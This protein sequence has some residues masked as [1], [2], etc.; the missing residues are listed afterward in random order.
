MLSTT[1]R[2][3]RSVYCAF[4]LAGACTCASGQVVYTDAPDTPLTTIGTFIDLDL[5]GSTDLQLFADVACTADFQFCYNSVNVLSLEPAAINIIIDLGP[6][7]LHADGA[8]AFTDGAEII[9]DFTYAPAAYLASN[10]GLGT[11]AQ[12]GTM[13]TPGTR[14]FG[15]I[16]WA[17]DGPHLAYVRVRNNNGLLSGFE[18]LDF[19]Y[20]SEPYAPII[21]GD[22]GQPVNPCP[23]D[24]N[25]DG[26]VDGSDVESFYRTFA[27]GDP[28]ADVNVDGGVDGAD[29][30]TFF[31]AWMAGGCG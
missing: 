21:A 4:L 25:N 29:V 13:I 12:Y 30:E 2:R 26:G 18:L 31:V 1:A 15:V 24:F 22:T 5:D 3:T 6:P 14:S 28:S 20:Q 10:S 23:A 9:A 8:A 11:A 27:S 19:A 17:S 16:H 7:L